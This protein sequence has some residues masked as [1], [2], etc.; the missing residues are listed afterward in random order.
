L[1]D[2]M[3]QGIRLVRGLSAAIEVTAVLLLLRMTNLQSMIRLNGVLGLVGPLIFIS[4]SALGLVGA[5]GTIP[6]HRLGLILLGVILVILGT[7]P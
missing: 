4:V 2:K 6:L 7:R 5:M 1:E 3:M